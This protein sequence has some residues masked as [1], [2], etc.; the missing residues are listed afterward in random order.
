MVNDIR[1]AGYWGDT[2]SND[3]VILLP[4]LTQPETNP[5]NQVDTT[6]PA[7]TTALRVHRTTDNGA[8]YVDRTDEVALADRTGSCIVYTYDADQDGVLDDNEKFGFRWAVQPS[9]QPHE[10]LKMRI[11]TNVAPNSCTGEG[12]DTDDLGN[13]INEADITDTGSIEITALNFS[14]ANSKCMNSSEPDGVDEDGGGVVDEFDEYNCYLATYAPDAGERTLETME[15]RIT[16]EAS[17]A[18]DSSVRASMTRSVLVRN[19][20]VR[21]R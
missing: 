6:T 9:A 5:F 3:P 8:T 7:N 14:L 1:R 10:V 12:W 21:V 2:S 11:P 19:Y 20:L 15:V 4:A 16:L 17:L 13:V 18:N